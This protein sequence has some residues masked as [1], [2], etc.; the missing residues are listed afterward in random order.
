M[1]IFDDKIFFPKFFLSQIY[2]LILPSKKNAVKMIF[3][4]RIKIGEFPWIDD[5]KINFMMLREFSNK[6]FYQI[7]NN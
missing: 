5:Q 3:F 6:Y 4:E 7:V 2:K 1:K